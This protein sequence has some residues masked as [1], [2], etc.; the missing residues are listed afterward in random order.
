MGYSLIRPSVYR[1]FPVT[2]SDSMSAVVVG[3]L[4]ATLNFRAVTIFN[5]TFTGD[6]LAD[7][8]RRSGK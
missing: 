2:A 6:K 8:A 1:G 3:D 4:F 7:L 5:F